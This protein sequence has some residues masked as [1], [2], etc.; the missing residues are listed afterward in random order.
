MAM[1]TGHPSSLYRVRIGVTVAAA[2]IL[3]AACGSSSKTASAGASTGSSAAPS[4]AASTKASKSGGS[5]STNLGGGSFCDKAKT[6]SAN[7]GAAAEDLTTA[8]PAKLKSFEQNALSEL[9]ALEGQAP[10]E[11]KGPITTLVDAE[12]GLV[13]ALQTANYDFTK[14]SPE[15]ASQ[16]ST[17]AFTAAVTKIDNY[18]ET[19]CGINPSAE[20]TP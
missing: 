10:S 1:S 15:F 13:N 5:V 4:A 14:L 6:A 3:L 17:P 19:K 7:V 20:P 16:F 2:G 18:L 9:K 12:S 8:T 11:I